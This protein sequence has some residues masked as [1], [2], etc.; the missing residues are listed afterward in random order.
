MSALSQIIIVSGA[1]L[2]SY[3]GVERVRRWGVQAGML[4]D[5]PNERSFHNASVPRG[6]GGYS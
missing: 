3:I 6:G 2:V 1:F 5:V 4:L